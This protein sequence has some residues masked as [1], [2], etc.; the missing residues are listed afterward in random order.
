MTQTNPDRLDR[1]EATLE[2][3]VLAIA[4]L[5]N[6]QNQTQEQLDQL[7]RTVEANS[8]QIAANTEQIALNT[9]QITEMRAGFVRLQNVLADYIA[10]QGR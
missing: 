1:I 9:E 7:Q 6:R 4:Q 2:T 10:S 3:T 8:H 5:A